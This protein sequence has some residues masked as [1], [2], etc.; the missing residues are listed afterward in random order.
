[1]MSSVI[2][3]H[4]LLLTSLVRKDN[5]LKIASWLMAALVIL[6]SVANV[7]QVWW[8]FVLW[9]ITNVYWVVFNIVVGYRTKQHGLY[10]QALQGVVLSVICVLGIVKWINT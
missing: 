8:C 5:M 10:A 6:G 1:M 3:H 2:L 9:L 4:G 7:Y